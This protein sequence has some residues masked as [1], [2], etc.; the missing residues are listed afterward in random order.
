[1]AGKEKRKGDPERVEVASVAELRDWLR[2][3]HRQ[4]ESI[5]LVT[6]KKHVADKYVAKDEIVD[7]VLCWGWIDSLPR[8]LDADRTMLR[9]SPRKKGSQWS[10]INKDKV[11]RLERQRRMR[12][13]GRR[14]IEQAKA[15][16]SWTFLDDVEALVKPGDLVA[17][18][19]AHPGAAENFDAFP[20]SAQRGLLG[21]IKLA[22]TPATRAKR[23]ATTAEQAAQNLMANFPPERAK[24]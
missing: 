5:W 14:K 10:K 22:R 18:F 20:P 17:A 21:W 24:R 11:T 13:P 15:D 2:V 1:M 6:Y 16:G 7:E 3:N 23:I 19:A 8:K 9:L 4:S 12:A